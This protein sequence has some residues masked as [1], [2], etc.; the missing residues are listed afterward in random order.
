MGIRGV[1]HGMG[2]WDIW[3]GCRQGDGDDEGDDDAAIRA[4]VLTKTKH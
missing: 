1:F 4:K 3:P 2:G